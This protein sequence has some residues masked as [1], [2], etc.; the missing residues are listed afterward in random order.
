MSTSRSTM[1]RTSRARARS[2]RIMYQRAVSGSLSS[3]MS[4]SAAGTA[5]RPSISRQLPVDD[6]AQAMR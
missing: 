1:L 2:P 6:N 3:A 4:T 5:A